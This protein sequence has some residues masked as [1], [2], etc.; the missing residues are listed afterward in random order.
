[1]RRIGRTAVTWPN[2]GEFTTVSIVMYCTV[3]STLL[4]NACTDSTFVWL[5]V[6]FFVSPRFRTSVPGPMM[7]FRPALP[8]V[9]AA[10]TENAAVLKN[11]IVVGSLTVIGWP[12]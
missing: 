7:V 3:L 9:P 8:Y 4:A 10:G 2:V 1:M 5:N 11:A 6:M 12:L